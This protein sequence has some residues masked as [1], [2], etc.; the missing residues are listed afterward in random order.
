MS[1]AKLQISTDGQ[2]I[3]ETDHT[4]CLGVITD[5]K[6]NGQNHISYATRNITG[7]IGV[8]TK[9]RKLLDKETLI[10]LYHICAIVIMYGV[11]SMFPIW[12]NCFLWSELFMIMV[13]IMIMI[14]IIIII[15]IMLLLSYCIEE[16]W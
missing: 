3:D 14:I 10:T 5:S 6:L 8:I 16:T 15:I 1:K 9:A 2:A 4:K 7:E 11:I 12:K 13:I